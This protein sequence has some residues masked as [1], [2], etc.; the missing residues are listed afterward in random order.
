L[1]RGEKRSDDPALLSRP[2]TRETEKGGK[3]AQKKRVGVEK[4]R[5]YAMR[6]LTC[7]GKKTVP[8]KRQQT[9]LINSWGN[10][11]KKPKKTSDK[12]TSQGNCSQNA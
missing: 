8:E 12:G 3:K 10:D 1:P 11:R 7:K 6:G 5:K 4:K 2:R 9:T